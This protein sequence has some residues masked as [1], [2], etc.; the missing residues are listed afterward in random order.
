MKWGVYAKLISGMPEGGNMYLR[1]Q[2]SANRA[3]IATIMMRFIDPTAEKEG[4]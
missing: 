1:P 3:Q 4:K 2:G